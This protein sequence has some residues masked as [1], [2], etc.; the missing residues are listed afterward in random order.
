MLGKF[1][2]INM[3]FLQTQQAIPVATIVE[4]QQELE[5]PVDYIITSPIDS[6]IKDDKE[7]FV[8]S[9]NDEQLISRAIEEARCS[10]CKMRHG[11]VASINGKYIAGGHNH[12]R[13][14]SS[15]GVLDN[16]CSC[17]AEMDVL[18]KCLKTVKSSKFKK[19]TFYIVRISSTGLLGCSAPCM[20][21]MKK[22]ERFKIKR[23][24]YSTDDG[25]FV[26][27]RSKDY[28]TEF[29]TRSRKDYNKTTK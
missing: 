9:N 28:N 11:C 24:V 17:H 18:F 4:E 16:P 23:L 8:I 22:L 2:I 26:S 10:P 12:Y 15:N 25:R 5:L 19:M 29:V 3:Y 21:C 6:S 7:S 13:I 20:D 27:I 14:Y 1:I